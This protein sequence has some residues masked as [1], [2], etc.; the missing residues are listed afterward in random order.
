MAQGNF[1]TA[2]PLKHQRKDLELALKYA[3]SQSQGLPVANATTE[4]FKKVN[5]NLEMHVK[6][7][8]AKMC[9]C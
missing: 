3:E 2:F 6:A 4:L 8:C 9:V 7:A 5:T 1:P